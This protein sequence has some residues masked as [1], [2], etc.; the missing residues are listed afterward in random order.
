[1]YPFHPKK[2]TFH[3]LY[4]KDSAEVYHTLWVLNITSRVSL[5]G[6]KCQSSLDK[7]TRR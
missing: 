6:K 3:L 4:E 2:M 1:M 5:A 7:S